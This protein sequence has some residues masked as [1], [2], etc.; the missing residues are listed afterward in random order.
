MYSK[1]SVIILKGS[2]LQL[3][4]DS[5]MN[6]FKVCEGPGKNKREKLKGA[7]APVPYTGWTKKVDHF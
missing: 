5:L 7:R 1:L 3:N 2:D 6:S 4:K